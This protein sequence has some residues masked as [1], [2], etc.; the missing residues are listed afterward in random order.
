MPAPIRCDDRFYSKDEYKKLLPGNRVYL[1]QIRD[2]RKGSTTEQG[3]KRMKAA[4][5]TEFSRSL[6]VLASA[7]DHLQVKAGETVVAATEPTP[8]AVVETNA[9]NSA[10][11]RI[12]T[13]QKKA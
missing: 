10:L 9:T 7:V 5:G 2:K 3:T 4:N 12:E 13:R 11:Q 8:V 1:R 6:S